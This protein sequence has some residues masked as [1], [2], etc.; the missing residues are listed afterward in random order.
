[1]GLSFAEA[2]PDISET[3]RRFA[4]GELRPHLREFEAS[5]ALSD[6]VRE[7]YAALGFEMI[8]LPATVGGAGLGMIDR[9]RT[10][11]LLAEADAGGALAL[12]RFAP[13]AYVLE[14]FGGVELLNSVIAGISGSD[15]ARLALVV[16]ADSAATSDGLIQGEIPW[17]PASSADA[18]VGLGVGG[19]WMLKSGFAFEPVRGAALHAAGASRVR[20]SGK[21]V[22][23]WRDSAAANRALSKV[24][25]YYASLIWGVLTDAATFSRNYALERVA[26]GKPI[27]HHQA[28]AFLIVDMHIAVER[29]GLLIEDAARAIDAGSADSVAC[30]ALA[31][32]D[33]VEASRFVGPNGVQIL[34]GHGFMRDFPVEKAMRD[35]RALGLLGGGVDAAREDAGRALAA[36]AQVQAHA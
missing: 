29:V 8:D 18:L 26:F 12:D 7:R 16:G 25:L 15:A 19:A 13:A 23:V 32:V 14:A 22:H 10:N 31:F 3:V 9:V 4:A 21:P 1:M 33:A 36:A 11:R 30:A 5:R 20:F 24:R 28:L 17:M 34:G 2:D 6:A 35:C 27:A